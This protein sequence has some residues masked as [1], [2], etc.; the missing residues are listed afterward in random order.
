MNAAQMISKL[1]MI[2]VSSKIEND[3]RRMMRNERF[4]LLAA[5]ASRDGGKLKAAMAEAVKVAD[6]WGV[7]LTA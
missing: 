2:E 7:S 5:V 3:T 4:A 1:E 6:M